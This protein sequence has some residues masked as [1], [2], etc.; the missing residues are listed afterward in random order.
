MGTLISFFVQLFLGCVIFTSF[1][2]GMAFLALSH[3]SPDEWSLA[4]AITTLTLFLTSYIGLMLFRRH[5]RRVIAARVPVR[6]QRTKRS[7][8]AEP[9]P[10]GPPKWLP[11]VLAEVHSA[12][13]SRSFHCRQC[14]KNFPIAQSA[15]F[16]VEHE[17]DE[18]MDDDGDYHSV[19]TH[20]LEGLVCARCTRIV[21][22]FN[23]RERTFHMIP[24]ELRPDYES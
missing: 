20:R 22:A 21:G 2:C 18:E 7:Q 5:R 24:D 15:S 14:H 1:C 13:N 12:V 3:V 17:R 9:R 10:S 6:V 11:G 23:C 8:S 19:M 16:V 4:P